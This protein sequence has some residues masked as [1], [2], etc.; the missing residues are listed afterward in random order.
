MARFYMTTHTTLSDAAFALGRSGALLALPESSLQLRASSLH[1][2]PATLPRLGFESTR[3]QHATY[4]NSSSNKFDLSGNA[5]SLRW[6]TR[7][8]SATNHP[9]LFTGFEI[10]SQNH[11]QMVLTL[12]KSTECNFETV[13]L[14]AG[15]VLFLAMRTGEKSRRVRGRSHGGKSEER[16]LTQLRLSSG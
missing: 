3:S 5:P 6:V 1:K 2:L 8:A 12:S 15:R 11:L 9:S 4:A 13:R 14:M 10:D 16:S 7:L